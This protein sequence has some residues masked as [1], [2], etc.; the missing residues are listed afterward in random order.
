MKYVLI[1]ASLL[2]LSTGAASAAEGNSDPFPFTAPGGL[3]AHIPTTPGQEVGQTP[4]MST[5]PPNAMN[6]GTRVAAAVHS[7][8]QVV[9]TSSRGV[10]PTV[11][12]QAPVQT[13]N[14]LPQGFQNGMTGY[15]QARSVQRYL[16]QQQQN[17][18]RAYAH[19]PDVARV[20]AGG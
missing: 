15:E 1:A 4:R 8:Y 18:A 20:G 13:A 5:K 9:G 7:Q 2:A 14:S 6:G 10:L 12:S 17:S 11:G 3:M 19:S 16:A